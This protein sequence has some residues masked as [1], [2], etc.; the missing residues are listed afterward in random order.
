MTG[1][2]GAYQFLLPDGLFDL[3][4]SKT[5]FEPAESGPQSVEAG[6]RITM[7]DVVLKTAPWA[8]SGIVTDSR[9]NRVGG[10]VVTIEYGGAFPASLSATAADDGRYRIASTAPHFDAVRLSARNFGYE[11]LSPQQVMLRSPDDAIYDITLVRVLK[12][13]MTG[14][15][16]LRVGESV[17]LPPATIDVDNGSQR[18]IYLLPSSSDRTVVAVEN[19]QRGFVIR[20]VQPGIAIVTFDYQGV[21]ATLRV[22]VVDR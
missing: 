7:P 2:D 18:V 1:A 5:G 15:S 8:V 22:Q 12:V 14:P 9:G 10:A 17:E 4:W 19:G 11:P 21:S 3:R 16:T 13:T 20:G 6:D